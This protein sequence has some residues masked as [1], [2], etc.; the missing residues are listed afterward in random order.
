M[1]GKTQR[2]H[3]SRYFPGCRT[4]RPDC[5]SGAQCHPPQHRRFRY[6]IPGS[7]LK[8]N[9]LVYLFAAVAA[10]DPAVLRDRSDAA[11]LQRKIFQQGIHRQIPNILIVLLYIGNQDTW[12]IRACHRGKIIECPIFFQTGRVCLFLDSQRYC[13][14][15]GCRSASPTAAWRCRPLWSA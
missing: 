7:P 8:K 3:S 2:A 14:H 9:C 4:R 1:P 10:D 15:R 12:C 13:V 5:R 6:I 11:K